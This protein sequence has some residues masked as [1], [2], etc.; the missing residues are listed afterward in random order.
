MAKYKTLALTLPLAF[1]LVAV[2]LGPIQKGQEPNTA[3][4]AS[5]QKRKVIDENHYPMAEFSSSEVPDLKRKKRGEKHNNSQWRVDPNSPADN[6]AIVDAVDLRLPAFPTDKAAAVVIG[7]VA[8][9]KAHLSNDKTGVY[10]SFVVIIEEVLKNPG[11]L[12]AGKSIEVEREGGRVK[13][14]SGR[15]HLYTMSDQHM[16]LVG[17]RYVFFLTSTNEESVFEIITGYEIR[18]DAVYALDNLTNALSY[19]GSTPVNFLK[20]LRTKLATKP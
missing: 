16:P 17:S 1:G 9:A 14:P 7:T 12:L 5:P 4:K 15:V 11:K 13:F 3:P 18:A 8:D 2:F 20:E 6:T 10:S 19:D